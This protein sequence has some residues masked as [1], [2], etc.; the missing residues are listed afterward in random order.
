MRR[1]S[2]S[3]GDDNTSHEGACWDLWIW[4]LNQRDI[5]R[6]L[7]AVLQARPLCRS[8][9]TSR[10]LAA[11]E[12]P[13][14][15]VAWISRCLARLGATLVVPPLYLFTIDAQTKQEGSTN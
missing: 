10:S 13:V 5:A 8:V 14:S 4:N 15:I 6:D 3:S 12:T 11:F 2:R 7:P 1:G 9:I